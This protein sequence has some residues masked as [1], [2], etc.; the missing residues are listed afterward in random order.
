M[1]PRGARWSYLRV[2]HIEHRIR[3]EDILGIVVGLK[4][5]LDHNRASDIK[6][7]QF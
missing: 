2:K 7:A 4:Y 5:T 6:P 1:R 3:F